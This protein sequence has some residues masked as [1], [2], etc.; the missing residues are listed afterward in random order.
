MYTTARLAPFRIATSLTCG[1][2]AE[3]TAS[4]LGM[5]YP[6]SCFESGEF[7]TPPSRNSTLS[8]HRLRSQTLMHR[9][10][11]ATCFFRRLNQLP[12]LTFHAKLLKTINPQQASLRKLTL[13][14]PIWSWF[15]YFCLN[16]D[17]G[18]GASGLMGV[19]ILLTGL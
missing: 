7:G 11:A 13:A 3:Y 8:L 17:S 6:S 1:A 12:N 4:N 18:L 2:E 16:L 5:A 19:H 14:Q 10:P 15:D 9:F